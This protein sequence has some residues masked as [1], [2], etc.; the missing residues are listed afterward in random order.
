MHL[1]KQLLQSIHQG[2][3]GL[4]PAAVTQAINIGKTCEVQPPP[5]ESPRT[6][7]V[8]KPVDKDD[9]RLEAIGL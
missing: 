3:K 7:I 6:D 1:D 4:V 8:I 9:G 5:V 2:R